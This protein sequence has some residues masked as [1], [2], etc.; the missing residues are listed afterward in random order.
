MGD[1]KTTNMSTSNCKFPILAFALLAVANAYD[2][3]TIS[4]NGGCPTDDNQPAQV[5]EWTLGTCA[6]N[7]PTHGPTDTY[8]HGQNASKWYKV[9]LSG[10][11]YS[12]QE[13]TDSTCDTA[14]R[15]DTAISGPLDS[16]IDMGADGP[17]YSCCV[18]PG[19]GVGEY[20]KFAT[21]VSID[22]HGS[23]VS[24]WACTSG[25]CCPRSG[26]GDSWS[27]SASHATVGAIAA[28]IGLVANLFVY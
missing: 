11:T 21:T 14:G 5:T 7:R 19:S 28:L 4:R 10:S 1:I 27:N 13:Y 15:S 20:I 9:T 6:G 24:E 2:V 22:L 18:G 26:C 8:P 17:G 16:C 23:G 25:G 12:Y 3:L